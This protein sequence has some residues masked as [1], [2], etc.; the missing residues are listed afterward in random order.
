MASEEIDFQNAF[1]FFLRRWRS[2]CPTWF[3]EL[4]CGISLSKGQISASAGNPVAAVTADNRVDGG[5]CSQLFGTRGICGLVCG[6]SVRPQWFGRPHYRK[7]SFADSFL[8]G[9]D[10][11]TESCGCGWQ[12]QPCGCAYGQAKENLQDQIISVIKMASDRWLPL[13]TC[14]QAFKNCCRQQRRNG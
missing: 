14:D 8:N 1:F 9:S 12:W 7:P 2:S 5:R 4:R 13:R 11:A 6:R 3:C 10:T